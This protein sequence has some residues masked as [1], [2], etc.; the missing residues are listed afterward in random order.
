[1]PAPQWIDHAGESAQQAGQGAAD[2]PNA[3]INTTDDSWERNN[4]LSGSYEFPYRLRLGVNY[5]N[6]S[7][8]PYARQVLFSGGQTIPSVV[9]N[10][11][12]I[13]TRTRPDINL[14][15]IRLERTFNFWKDKKLSARAN[16][17]N[18]LNASTVT[19]LNARAGT[20]RRAECNRNS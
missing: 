19:N 1:M 20:S 11:E 9:L 8:L 5:Q 3:E 15:D 10:V 17:Y 13:G 4:K 16:I 7:G 12:P 2:N 18:L 14:V 6:R